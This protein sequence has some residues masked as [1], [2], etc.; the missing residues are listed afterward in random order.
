M[1]KGVWTTVGAYVMWGVLPIYWKFLQ[2][3]PS[4]Q[5]LAHR[6]IW[7]FLFILLVL[8]WTNQWVEFKYAMRHRA[9]RNAFMLNGFIVS[10]NWFVY[11]WAVNHGYIIEAS[12]GYYI[13]PLMS[14]VLGVVVFRESLN[15]VQWTAVG[16]ATLGV[17]VL[18]FG[19]GAFPW[20]SFVLAGTFGFYSLVKKR[21]P[22]AS[23]V[24]LGIETLAVV[25]LALVFLGVEAS[26]GEM[27]LTTSPI[28]WLALFGTGVITA[29]PLLLFG[30]GAQHIPFTLVG[31]LQFIAPSLSLAIGVLLYAE[32][33]TSYHVFAFTCIWLAILFFSWNSW[34]IARK[35]R[36][37][38]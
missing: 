28:M 19:Y 32:P 10:S 13:N 14:M 26:S 29:L 23:T 25:P 20:I 7:S 36:Q 22:L 27:V 34:V 11:I 16:I 2:E 35:R 6:I 31:F 33:F 37:F 9:T 24:S 4:G 15:R 8:K 3:V 30:Y 21:R 5:I 38:V 12:L 1:N 18:T 17:L